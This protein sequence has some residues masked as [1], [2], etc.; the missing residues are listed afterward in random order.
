[1]VGLNKKIAYVDLRY[2][3]GFAVRRPTEAVNTEREKVANVTNNHK[4]VDGA[5]TKPAD[6]K[7]IKSEAMKKRTG[8]VT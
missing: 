8:T 1:L 6:T 5:S 7:S 3:S 4:A 2:P